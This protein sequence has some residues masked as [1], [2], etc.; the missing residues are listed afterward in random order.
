MPAAHA[1][2]QTFAAGFS[3]CGGSHA[4]HVDAEPTHCPQFPEQ[5]EQTPEGLLN[6]R[7]GHAVTQVAPFKYGASDVSLQLVQAFDP[8]EKQVAHDVSQ[9]KQDVPSE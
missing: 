8:E 2:T 9:A 5:N 6:V 3:S 1:D 7:D 4:V